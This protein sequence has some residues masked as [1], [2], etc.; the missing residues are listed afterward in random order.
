MAA[1][2]MRLPCF[3]INTGEM[4]KKRGGRGEKEKR[5]EQDRGEEKEREREEWR[6]KTEKKQEEEE[7]EKNK[8]QRR[9][10]KKKEQLRGPLQSLHLLPRCFL[11]QPLPAFACRT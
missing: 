8:K 5:E 6:E 9:E 11:A 3:S 4:K 2:A 7:A 1:P 10:R